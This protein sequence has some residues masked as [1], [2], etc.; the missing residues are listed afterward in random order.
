MWIP[1]ARAARP[2][3]GHLPQPRLPQCRLPQGAPA[4]LGRPAL[5]RRASVS[6]QG[7]ADPRGLLARSSRRR[8]KGMRRARRRAVRRHRLRRAPAGRGA[9]RRSRCQAARRCGTLPFAVAQPSCRWHHCHT[10]LSPPHCAP[11]CPQ[12]APMRTARVPQQQNA[13]HLPVG[14]RVTRLAALVQRVDQDPVELGRGPYPAGLVLYDTRCATPT[15][16]IGGRPLHAAPTQGSAGEQVGSRGTAERRARMHAME[17]GRALKLSM[18]VLNCRPHTCDAGPGSSGPG[19]PGAG[20]TG[21]GCPGAGRPGAGR[22]GAGSPGPGCSSA[23]CSGPSSPGS[24]CP[25]AGCPCAGWPCAGAHSQ[26][27]TSRARARHTAASR[28]RAPTGRGMSAAAC[29]SNLHA[30]CHIAGGELRVAAASQTRASGPYCP[31]STA[32]HLCKHAQQRVS[33][34]KRSVPSNESVGHLNGDLAQH[35]RASL[36]PL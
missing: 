5:E 24:G 26:L 7:R 17:A 6:S 32:T 10:Q 21:A 28:Q 22:P 11:P 8:Q 9:H 29:M 19:C 23:G 3:E 14:A 36:R 35:R 34:G 12:R 13:A 2:R 18:L 1:A 33:V 30:G 27:A 20:C 15:P 4:S 16:S 31:H 25:G